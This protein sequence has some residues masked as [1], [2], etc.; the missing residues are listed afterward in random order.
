M[1]QAK[2]GMLLSNA[3]EV[4]NDATADKLGKYYK[5]DMPKS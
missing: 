1:V 3:V 2:R 5:P 4:E